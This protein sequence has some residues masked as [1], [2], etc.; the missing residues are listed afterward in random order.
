MIQLSCSPIWLFLFNLQQYLQQLQLLPQSLP[1]VRVQILRC[2]F[3]TNKL[4]DVVVNLSCVKK[5]F[6]ARV[7]N[8]LSRRIEAKVVRQLAS[9]ETIGLLI[10]I[11]QKWINS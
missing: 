11:F 3:V 6:F 10:L 8:F 1:L 9:T 7:Q 4:S 5:G 2:I